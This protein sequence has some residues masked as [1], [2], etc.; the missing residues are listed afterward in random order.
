MPNNESDITLSAQ[1]P[2][3]DTVRGYAI[4]FRAD[5]EDRLKQAEREP[6]GTYSHS[7][8][9]QDC[10]VQD[11][12]A[13][14]QEVALFDPQHFLSHFQ[15]FLA[16]RWD[17]IQ[18]TA[19]DYFF[20]PRNQST[21]LPFPNL[22]LSANFL[23]TYL[24]THLHSQTKCPEN[25][26]EF[27]QLFC[28]TITQVSEISID[29]EIRKAHPDTRPSPALSVKLISRS[30]TSTDPSLSAVNLNNLPTLLVIKNTVFIINNAVLAS[31]RACTTV[32]AFLET[33]HPDLYAA[34]RSHNSTIEKLYDLLSELDQRKSPLHAIKS[35]I[36]ALRNAGMSVTGEYHIA[37]D[38]W[39][40]VKE[41][42]RYIESYPE[43]KRAALFALTNDEATCTFDQCYTRLFDQSETCV[44]GLAMILENIVRTN[45]ANPLLTTP[46][47]LSVEQRKD[48]ERHSHENRKS[49]T[50]M[51]DFRSTTPFPT[52]YYSNIPT[53]FRLL[54]PRKV[55]VFLTISNES[56]LYDAVLGATS[57]IT[58][59]NAKTPQER[60]QKIASALIELSP[61]QYALFFKKGAGLVKTWS[62]Y[63][64]I[65]CLLSNEGA[66]I[67]ADCLNQHLGTLA[68]LQ[69]DNLATLS[70]AA[71]NYTLNKH[72]SDISNLVPT[73]ADYPNFI[74]LLNAP[75]LLRE[76]ISCFLAPHLLKLLTQNLSNNFLPKKT[77]YDIFHLLMF[78]VSA[79][80][81]LSN[82]LMKKIDREF[83]RYQRTYNVYHVIKELVTILNKQA[84]LPQ[85]LLDEHAT[86]I[87]SFLT[88]SNELRHLFTN[89]LTLEDGN[90]CIHNFIRLSST[91]FAQEFK[92]VTSHPRKISELLNGLTQE[93]CLKILK[94]LSNA[95]ISPIFTLSFLIDFLNSLSHHTHI[96]T[97][98]IKHLLENGKLIEQARSIAEII[99]VIQTLLDKKSQASLYQTL[100]QENMLP[101]IAPLIKTVSDFISIV[102]K[103]PPEN[104]PHLYSLVKLQTSLLDHTSTEQGFIDV[105]AACSSEMRTQLVR[106]MTSEKTWP[107][108]TTNEH[109]LACFSQLSSETFYTL[110]FVGAFPTFLQNDTL[111]YLFSSTKLDIDKKRELCKTMLHC[112]YDLSR[113]ITSLP[114]LSQFLLFSTKIVAS[115]LLGML[116]RKNLLLTCAANFNT[117]FALVKTH[118]PFLSRSNSY[119]KGFFLSAYQELLTHYPPEKVIK[120]SDAFRLYVEHLPLEQR[121]QI[122][123]RL[124]PIL[125]EFISNQNDIDNL[126]THLPKEL[127]LEFAFLQN[128]PSM[129]PSLATLPTFWG[130]P[131]H[132]LPDQR[133][134][135]SRPLEEAA[136]SSAK[137]HQGDHKGRPYNDF[138]NASHRA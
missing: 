52:N 48:L 83:C 118:S 99:S 121:K 115:N 86:L 111:T 14:C 85:A 28:P 112:D 32:Y 25:A 24:K 117:L 65:A 92:A 13:I 124:R 61:T 125:P 9:W 132:R 137:R 95:P 108:I 89:F 82:E 44:E 69:P 138:S 75:L 93:K 78:S 38:L 43:E 42:K 1:I 70:E 101:K 4:Q 107:L 79:L 20:P 106:N 29:A 56:P 8:L 110:Y 114:L 7:L 2:T 66:Q 109:V 39:S 27:I 113:V 62:D 19:L 53:N 104:Q 22:N 128:S 6:Q 80:G 116:Q 40:H 68:P 54:L 84:S 3:L 63:F 102:G 45:A 120:N 90:V 15:T 122:Y 58:M 11:Y 91:W 12:D 100:S 76:K 60:A 51:R 129:R 133:P 21:T 134:L 35:L 36:L 17:A 47:H 18:G 30:F 103:I 96:K 5:L 87:K 81:P 23:L 74:N 98:F 127:E 119:I 34:L 10:T 67:M 105:I 88:S 16:T 57:V 126:K 135:A 49:L 130:A 64:E 131:L 73:L 94:L 37:Q 136:C 50:T 59:F 123:K 46:S 97:E 26:A 33:H 72:L 55:G 41:F 71:L 31:T 77:S